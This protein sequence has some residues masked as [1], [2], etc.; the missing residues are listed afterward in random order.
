MT[1]EIKLRPNAPVNAAH[2]K[3]GP[4]EAGL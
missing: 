2:Q 3:E 4:R 1:V